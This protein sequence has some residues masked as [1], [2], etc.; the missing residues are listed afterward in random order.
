MGTSGGFGF[1]FVFFEGVSETNVTKSTL[2]YL[3]T[4]INHRSFEN[5]LM[6]SNYFR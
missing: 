5:V 4:K 1:L 6:K 3:E 2:F